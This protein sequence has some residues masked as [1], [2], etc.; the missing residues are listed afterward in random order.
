MRACASFAA[1]MNM[2]EHV[3]SS[4][5][6]AGA[7]AGNREVAMFRGGECRCDIGIGV[8][9]VVILMG[10]DCKTACQGCRMCCV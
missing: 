7:G 10:W 6:V 4:L 1:N 9:A 5:F 8:S 2:I 3:I